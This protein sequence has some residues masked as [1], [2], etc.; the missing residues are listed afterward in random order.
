[1]K[2]GQLMLRKII[3]ILPTRCQ[4]L[5]LKCT[6]VDFSTSPDP[7]AGIKLSFSGKATGAEKTE[8]REQGG[9]DGNGEK[10][11]Y[12]KGRKGGRDGGGGERKKGIG[13]G[14]LAIPILIC[15]RHCCPLMRALP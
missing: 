11:G 13:K 12:R 9:M 10:G 1:M 2:F 3:K 8:G 14:R 6:K 4:T 7:L 5:R 15:F